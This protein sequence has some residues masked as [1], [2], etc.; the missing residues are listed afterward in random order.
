LQEKSPFI[1][2]AHFFDLLC[3]VHDK[4]GHC[5]RDF[6]L[7]VLRGCGWW[8]RRY[9]DVK[10]YICT[11]VS[12]QVN[13]QAHLSQETGVQV[14]LP[15][16]LPFERFLSDLIQMP[17]SYKKKYKWITARHGRLLF[18]FGKLLQL[19][20]LRPFLSMLSHRLARLRSF[21]RIA[22]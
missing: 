1:P 8:L 10:N 16:V 21:L 5:G 7:Q 14:P 3:E 20:W 22:V 13:E 11:C 19:S 9:E 15:A 4:L 6:T 18:R 17:E 2:F 12:C